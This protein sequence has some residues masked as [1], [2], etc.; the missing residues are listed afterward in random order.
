MPAEVSWSCIICAVLAL[1][2][3]F[4]C[5]FRSEIAA[6][7][8]RFQAQ[9]RKPLEALTISLSE[10]LMGQALTAMMING[11]DAASCLHKKRS[12]C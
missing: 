5:L 7:S 2:Q 12:R 9:Q 6:L 11:R 8:E 4:C 3:E 10:L 1:E